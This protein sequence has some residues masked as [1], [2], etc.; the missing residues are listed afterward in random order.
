MLMSSTTE[1]ELQS[2]IQ[3]PNFPCVGAK[4]ALGK[5]QLHTYTARQIDSAWND[6]EIQDRLMQF[7][8]NYTQ[9]KTL[10]TSF[11]VIFEGPLDLTEKEFERFMWDRIQSLTEKD[12]WRGQPPDPRVSSDPNDPHFSLSFGGEAFFVV[13]LHPHASRPARRFAYPTMI[14]NLHDQF[15]TLREQNRYEK[16]RASILDRDEKL[17][18]SI[19]PMLARHGSISEARQY[20][21]R[22]VS[23]EW[24]CPYHRD[25]AD[26]AA[27]DPLAALAE[28]H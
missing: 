20:S 25:P 7:A 10:F 27:I 3:D 9:D 24:A 22:A 13:G 4:S 14:F 19:N 21:G 26:K 17:A 6:V 23:E 12:A 15:E 11:A 28:D 8:W 1:Q 16:L 5:G 2:F 18:G